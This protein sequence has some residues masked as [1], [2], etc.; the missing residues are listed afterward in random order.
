MLRS[1]GI[2]A[3]LATGYIPRTWDK[4]NGEFIVQAR[5]YHAWPEVY[6]PSYG[7]VEFEVT[8][9]LATQ[10]DTADAGIENSSNSSGNSDVFDFL[11]NENFNQPDSSSGAQES[12][13]PDQPGPRLSLIILSLYCCDYYCSGIA[14]A[15]VVSPV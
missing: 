15:M 7:W 5:D 12:T 4:K 8:P 2:P 11:L 13:A 6:F 10:I 14:A 1:I 9:G 3:R